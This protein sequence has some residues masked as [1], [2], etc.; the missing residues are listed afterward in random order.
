MATTAVPSQAETPRDTLVMAWTFDDIITLDPAEIFEFSAAE[1][2]GNTYD[3]LIAYDLEDVS[4]IYGEA[5]ES[6]T[7]SDDGKTFTF[8]M[9]EGVVFP[10]GNPMTAEDAAFSLQRAVILD[11]SPAFILTQFGFTADN[12]RDK[13]KAVDDTTLVIE[14]DQAYATTLVLY[15]LTS[16][17]ASIVDKKLVMEHEK[18][19]DLG[20]NWL[21]TNY[22]GVGPFKFGQWRPNELLTLERNDGYWGGAPAMKRVVIR[23]IA[24]P[25]TQQL[26]LEKGDID[27]ARNLGPD[28]LASLR[29]NPDITIDSNVKGTVY[30][31]GLNQKNEILSKPKVRQA[32]KYL[33]DYKGMEGTVVQDLMTVHQAFLPK[34]FLGALE[35]TP[36]TLDV[37]RAKT[38]LAEAGYPDG[39]KITMDTRN[40]S[41]IMEMA[42]A[43]QATFAQAGIELEIIPGDGG[44]TLTKYRA[45]NHDI[46]IGQWGPDYQDPHTN[47]DTF[48][49]NPDNSDDAQSKPL[50]WRNA[51]DIPEMTK[52]AD[53][54]ALERDSAK[55]AEMYLELQKVHQATSP[56]VI[57][58]Q[59]IEVAAVRADTKGFIIGPSFDDNLYAKVT[60]E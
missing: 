53:A 14:T 28:Q 34:G 39:F 1:F 6:W 38:L 49:R 59:Q 51:W 31:L 48:A 32:L 57:M 22:A 2:A 19:G 3:R 55:R 46:Y 50:A 17:V 16:T 56:F 47:A 4:K 37:D 23:H 20:Y 13:I 41:P 54:A 29:D 43:I 5:A 11:K 18:D 60:K 24:E 27:I 12:V 52:M 15:C 21:K 7:V 35:A 8:K 33:V 42:Q 30:Y 44:Q 45:R 36:F 58:F 40:T 10:S 9:R 25:A 26:L